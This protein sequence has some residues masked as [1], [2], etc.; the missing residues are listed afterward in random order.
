MINWF[1]LLPR[2]FLMPTSLE[3]C[4]ACAVGKIDKVYAGN[5]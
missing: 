2:T 1:L 3:R 5:S 4:T